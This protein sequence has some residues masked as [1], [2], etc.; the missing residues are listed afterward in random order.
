MATNPWP[1]DYLALAV[2]ALYPGAEYHHN[3]DD[4]FTLWIHSEPQPDPK[5]VVDKW[6]AVKGIEADE[7][8]QALEESD[9]SM[10]RTAESVID[11]LIAKGTI[12]SSDLP[13]EAQAILVKR[14]EERTKMANAKKRVDEI[15]AEE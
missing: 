9:K 14:K 3:A 10:A 15:P 1:T 13:D 7:A 6:T 4:G 8:L 2:A 5:T 12:E 11:A